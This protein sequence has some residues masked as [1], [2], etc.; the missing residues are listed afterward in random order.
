MSSPTTPS[1]SKRRHSRRRPFFSRSTGGSCLRSTARSTRWAPTSSRESS[2][3]AGRRTTR[4]PSRAC[5]ASPASWRLSSPSP[6]NCSRRRMRC[7]RRPISPRRCATWWHRRSPPTRTG[8]TC[9]PSARPCSVRCRCCMPS[10]CSAAS[11][12]RCTRTTPTTTARSMRRS[13]WTCAS[14]RGC[15][16][17]ISQKRRLSPRLRAASPWARSSLGC[18]AT[19]APSRS[20][21]CG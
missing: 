10:T 13:C 5:W 12:T 14:I 6:S 11:C 9:S 8:G 21:C 18:C 16:M 7:R 3:G 17:G 15:S 19:T 1:R 20:V 4:A 2:S